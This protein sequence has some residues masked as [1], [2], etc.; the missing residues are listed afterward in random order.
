MTSGSLL[1]WKK[2]E[3][4]LAIPQLIVNDCFLYKKHIV[5]SEVLGSSVL[6]RRFFYRM[7]VFLLQ[8]G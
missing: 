8:A 2:R 6:R 4:V 1:W 5:D 3:S 7:G